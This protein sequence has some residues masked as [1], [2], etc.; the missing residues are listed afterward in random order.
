M[1]G[2]YITVGRHVTAGRLVGYAHDEG[3]TQ[4]GVQ[5]KTMMRGWALETKWNTPYAH[6][7]GVETPPASIFFPRKSYILI[8]DPRCLELSP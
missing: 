7:L 4:P 1:V 8:L 2:T 5:T 6:I 3:H